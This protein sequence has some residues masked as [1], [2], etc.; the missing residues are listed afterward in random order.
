MFI[1]I[2]I[3]ML[4]IPRNIVFNNGYFYNKSDPM[5]TDGKI[6]D[7]T[8]Y[9]VKYKYSTLTA[10]WKVPNEAFILSNV[11]SLMES[12]IFL[13]LMD[14]KANYIQLFKSLPS[15]ETK[16]NLENFMNSVVTSML[17]ALETADGLYWMGDKKEKIRSQYTLQYC[18]EQGVSLASKKLLLENVINQ[19]SNPQNITKE[20]INDNFND[21]VENRNR[22]TG[23]DIANKIKETK[24]KKPKK[25]KKKPSKTTEEKK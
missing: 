6:E 22:E 25:P 12:S 21:L 24:I 23:I 4:D 7:G 15:N 9:K 14:K 20:H 11:E 8:A 16:T 17:L 2:Y 18:L 5:L 3:N 10:T 1:I 13:N 19:I